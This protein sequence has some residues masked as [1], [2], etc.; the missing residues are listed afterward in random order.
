MARGRLIFAVDLGGTN[1]RAGLVDASGRVV[2]RRKA[3]PRGDRRPAVFLNTLAELRSELSAEVKGRPDALALAVP[4]PMDAGRGWVCS[5]VNV[6]DLGRAPLAAMAG[7]A[8]G[9][10]VTL[11]NDATAFTLGEHWRGAAR[12]HPWCLGVTLGT[13]VGGGAVLDGKPL[14]GARGN[15][16]EIGHLTVEPGGRPCGCGRRGCL[17]A[18]ASASA[19]RRRAM[20]LAE[21]GKLP[22]LLA[23][24]GGDTV[25]I[26][27][28]LITEHARGGDRI[29][30]GLL[31]EAG[32]YLG[33]GL[34]L[35]Q[36]LLDVDLAVI[37]GGLA[38]AGEL[39]LSPARESLDLHRF[40]TPTELEIVAGELGGDAGLV[41]AAALALNLF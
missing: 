13:G 36:A 1:L 21:G 9:L 22:G 4:G 11:V 15:A 31:E 34:A 30:A 5:P 28:R 27:S 40:R 37:G 20:E 3:P 16:L 17:E 32:R 41:G 2:A 33:R 38:G 29:C 19:V 35:A 23:A 24:A 18:Y 12:G 7:K 10:P 26:N 8:L 14:L 39:I 6:P 25:N